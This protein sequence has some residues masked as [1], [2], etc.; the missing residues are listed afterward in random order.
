M[1]IIHSD[2]F[3]YDHDLSSFIV[4]DFNVKETIL[5]PYLKNPDN[6]TVTHSDLS[7]AYLNFIPY[8]ITDYY[9]ERCCTEY[10]W[11]GIGFGEWIVGG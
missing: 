9:K 10:V 2:S 8:V 5:F 7:R 1:M 4:L 3:A 6:I 11:E